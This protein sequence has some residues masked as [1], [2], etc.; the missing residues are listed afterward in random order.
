MT[1]S[2][3]A[4]AQDDIHGGRMTALGKLLRTT[5]FKLTLVCL[6]VFALFAAFLLG[7]FALNTRRLVTEQI[8]DTVNAEITGLEEQYRLGGI[9]RL[10]IVVDSRARRPGSSLYLVTTF[11]GESLTGN[12]GSLGPGGLAR[13]GWVE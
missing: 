4:P 11:T 3:P 6:T 2:F 5:T 12:V 13:S 8:I 1:V 9:R 7:Y 10:V